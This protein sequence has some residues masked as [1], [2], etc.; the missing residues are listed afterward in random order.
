MSQIALTLNPAE[1]AE[2]ARPINGNGGLQSFGRKLQTKIQTNGTIVLSDSEMG[3]II[4]YISYKPGG[5]EN[6]LAAAFT[7][8]IREILD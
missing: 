3:K 2:I 4:R 6:R 5:F 8:S 7:R 1:A